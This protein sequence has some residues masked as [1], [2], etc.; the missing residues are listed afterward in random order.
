MRLPLPQTFPHPPPPILGSRVVVIVIITSLIHIKS[1]GAIMANVYDSQALGP[2]KLVFFSEIVASPPSSAAPAVTLRLLVLMAYRS[3]YGD[4]DDDDGGGDVDTMEDVSCRVPLRDL[5]MARGGDGDDVGAVRAAAAERAFGELVAGLE[6]PTLRP[7][8][9]TEVPRAAARV[10]ARCEG[11]AEEE[12]AELEIRMHV[13]LIAHDA[14]REEGDG[15]DDE[16]GSDMDFSDVCGRRGDWGD[17][18]DAD[19]FLSDDDDDEGA[20]FA[21]RPYGGAML[22]EGGPS[23]GTLLLSGFATRSDGPELDDQLE[24]TPRDIRR[25][26]RM[27]LKGKNVERDEAYQRALDGGTPVSP[28]SLAAML[29]QAL[30]SVRQQPPQ[31]QQN[32]QNT[33]RDGG[34]VR[35]MHTGF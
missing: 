8:V 4:D 15:E 28:E 18:D 30:Q 32:C 21:A 2:H 5:T 24:L 6:H 23:D 10:L 25:L 12:V 11:R 26:V 33:T 16:S 1:S 31:Q 9:E 35:R 20:Q 3:S 7:E 13:V 14:P 27:A 22:R 34:V 17:G 29:D 19:A